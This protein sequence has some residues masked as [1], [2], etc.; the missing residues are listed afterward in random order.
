MSNLPIGWTEL[1]L[2]DLAE[3]KYGKS[4]PAKSRSGSGFP[5]YGSNGIVGFHS[6]ALTQGPTIVIGRKGSF[7]E[8]HFSNSSCHPIDTTYYIDDFDVASPDFLHK[9]LKTLPLKTLNRASAIPGLN[10][11]DAYACKTKLAP[12]N[13]QKRIVAKLESCESRITAA[14][15]ALDEVPALLEQYRQSILA[16]A[17]RGD[18]T[19]D[20]RAANPNTEP[21]SKLLTRLR[22]ERRQRWEKTTL[23]DYKA[24]DKE[25]PKNWLEKYKEPLPISPAEAENCPPIPDGWSW[26]TNEEISERVTVGHVGSM[27]KEY[28]DSGIAFLRGQNV[29]ENRFDSKNLLRISE[30][31]HEKL[32]K[33][34]LSPDDIVVT[35]SGEVGT[36]CVIPKTL[37]VANCSD[38]VIIQRPIYT[39]SNYLSFYINSEGKRTVKDGKVGVAITHFNTKSVARMPIA[40]APFAEQQEIAKILK[41]FHRVIEK[42]HE[43]YNRSA[44]D[45]SELSAS[46][47]KKA[48][49]G[50]LV[51]QEPNDEPASVLLERIKE[52]RLLEQQ[53]RAK[54]PKKKRISNATMS[55]SIPTTIQQALQGKDSKLST[56]DLFEKMGYANDSSSETVEAFLIQLRDAIADG[57]ISRTRENDEDYFSLKSS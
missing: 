42:L 37:P 3:L 20:W 28:R 9:L 40:V 1:T 33:S 32:K 43:T 26:S 57:A 16:A 51:N 21:A 45:I 11:S 6:T 23:A 36:A 18:L 54:R 27:K 35:R 12:A 8:V 29:R 22:Q 55:E 4:L 38:L 2:G 10:R 47:L 46:L 34:T 17:F 7:G 15:E 44:S 39:D 30:E 49:S 41:S 13:E 48:F 24:N 50:Q 5:V 53:I 56:S 52:K 31:F 19:K 25:P 14:R